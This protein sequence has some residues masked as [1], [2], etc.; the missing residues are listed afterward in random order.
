MDILVPSATI[1]DENWKIV[2]SLDALEHEHFD[3]FEKM[4]TDEN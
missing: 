4:T 1:D 2:K 3:V